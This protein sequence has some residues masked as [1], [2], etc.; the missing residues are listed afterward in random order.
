LKRVVITGPTG[1]LGTAL[2]KK[3]AELGIETYVVCHPGSKR[4]ATILKSSF[5]HKV[6][7]DLSDIR[8]LPG[9]I[10]ESCDT[11]FHLAW[12][13]TQNHNNRLD[14]Y[15]Q[16]DNVKYT[17]DAVEAAKDLGC[18]VF[19]GA[20]SQAEYG[21]VDG[22][23]HPDTVVQPVS[24]YGMAKL[25]AG[26]MTRLMCKNYGIRHIW[27]R[28]VSTYGVNDSPNTLVSVVVDQLLDGK[29]PS[30][31]AGEQIWDYLYA[32]DAAEAFYKMALHG[33]D[34]AVYVLGSGQTKP[35]KKFM[36]I[37]RDEIDTE[38]PLGLGEIPYYQDQA[39][40]LEADVA[41][42][43]AD[44]GWIPHIS[45]KEGIRALI[46]AKKNRYKQEI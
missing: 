35:L 32:E 15:L 24:G 41:S 31:T 8:S 4:T 1:V 45:F 40:H 11:F 10:G 42:L 30:L 7:C 18:K 38:I 2:T 19:V 34:G 26:Q 25:C 44:T 20:G 28:V 43:T 21:R 27:P 6:E 16:N 37:I 36:E 14:M 17:L 5:I 39:M 33:K 23:I 29:K 9:M 3:M 46:A 22:I 12:L 13:G